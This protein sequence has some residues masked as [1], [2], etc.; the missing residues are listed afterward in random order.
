[1]MRITGKI[2]LDEAEIEE[3]FI[4]ASGPGGQ[5][6]NKTATAVQLRFDVRQSASLPESVRERLLRIAGKRIDAR[7]VLTIEARRYREQPR[8]R[9]DA[10]ERLATLIRKAAEVPRT[11]VKTRP[12]RAAKERRLEEKRR[13]G[14]TKKHR[15]R[16]RPR[17][18]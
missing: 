18:E 17:D 14:E 5:N 6:V 1:M 8:N 13:R 10:L 3:S 15:S 12:T 11:R 2:V 4:L 7:G 16:V 9:R